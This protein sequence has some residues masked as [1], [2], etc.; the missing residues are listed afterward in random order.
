MAEPFGRC[1]YTNAIEILQK[2]VAEGKVA[3]LKTHG[4]LFPVLSVLPALDALE[5]SPGHRASNSD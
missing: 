5:F 4:P 2:S 3:L 1:T